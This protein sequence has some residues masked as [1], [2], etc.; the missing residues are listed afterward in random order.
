MFVYFTY[1]IVATNIFIDQKFSRILKL[2]RKK[3]LKH[4][5][6]KLMQ[7]CTILLIYSL[8]SELLVQEMN[9]SRCILATDTS[10]SIHFCDK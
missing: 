7:L 5:H 10:I 3:I 8:R 6:P 9:V 1:T 4:I 2:N